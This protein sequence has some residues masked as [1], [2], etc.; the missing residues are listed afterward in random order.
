MNSNEGLKYPIHLACIN[1]SINDI[2]I[3]LEKGLDVNEKSD[4]GL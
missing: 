1:N 4:D 3:L 2:K